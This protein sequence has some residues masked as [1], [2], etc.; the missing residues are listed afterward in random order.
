MQNQ[1]T[2]EHHK[3]MCRFISE[4]CGAGD[5]RRGLLQAFRNSGKSTLVGVFCAWILWRR[6]TARILILSADHGLAKKMA[7][8]IK[9]IVERHPLTARMKPDNAEEWASDRFTIRRPA[10]LRDP[11]VL[12]RGL[13]ANMTGCRADIVVCDDVEVPKTCAT[14]HKRADLRHKLSELDYILTP[15]G[16][17]LYIGTPHTTETIYDTGDGGFLAGWREMR[18]PVMDADGR[19]AWP[20]RFGSDKIARLKQHSGARKFLSQM[21]LTPVPLAESRLDAS[22]LR[23]YTDAPAYSEANGAARLMLGDTRLASVS[24]WW[25]PAF[26]SAA[27]DKSVVAVVFADDSGRYYLHHVRYLSVPPD[28]EA[29]A[30]QCAQVAQ[31]IRDHFLPSIRLETNGIGKFL[32]ALLRQELARTRTPCQVIEEV[33]RQNKALRIL[34]AFDAPLMNGNLFVH[35]SVKDTPFIQEMTD[36]APNGKAHDDGLDAVAGCLLSEPVRLKRYP[37][38]PTTLYKDWR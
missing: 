31:T 3:K 24:A 38:A 37:C 6:P 20:E 5:D 11:S 19:P 4:V 1:T 34:S 33:A 8:H 27:G 25:D 32:P 30:W 28:A 18:L 35:A 17:T 22:R 14:A 2:P 7:A 23:F 10:T 12:A 21:M 9:H 15:N 36:F 26:G 29:T 13:M 16:M